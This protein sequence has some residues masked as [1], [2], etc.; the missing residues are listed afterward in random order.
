MTE[1]YAGVS[2]TREVL[3]KS[4]GSENIVKLSTKANVIV[5]NTEEANVSKRKIE[6]K[7][8]IKDYKK[9]IDKNDLNEQEAAERLPDKEALFVPTAT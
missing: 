9:E 3:T 8:D 1:D 7:L 2:V 5:K 6:P 4:L